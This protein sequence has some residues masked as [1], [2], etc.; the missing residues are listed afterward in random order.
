MPTYILKRFR[1]SAPGA[2]TGALTD[3]YCFPADS[4]LE[5]KQKSAGDS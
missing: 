5:T 1:R 2:A 4:A 3:E